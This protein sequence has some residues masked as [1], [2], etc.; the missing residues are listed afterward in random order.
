M[1]NTPIESTMQPSTVAP[2]VEP[3]PLKNN[4]TWTKKMDLLFKW[5]CLFSGFL[6]CVVLF[7]IIYFVGKTGLLTFDE[8]SL[9]AFFFSTDWSPE[10]NK[11]GA[12]VFIIRTLALTALTLVIATPISVGIAIFL[13]EVAPAWLRNMLRPILDLLVGIPSVVYGYLGLT[14]LIPYLRE[15][16]G[17]DI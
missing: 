3:V 5:F 10:E 16:T 9:T 1:A 13:A 12:A 4:N 6:V 17:Q 7:S 11:F 15:V 8:V 2:L 14:V